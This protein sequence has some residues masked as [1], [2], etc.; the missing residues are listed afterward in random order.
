VDYKRSIAQARA[1]TRL[2]REL[3][4]TQARLEDAIGDHPAPPARPE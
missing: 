3:T 2:A 4:L 1:N